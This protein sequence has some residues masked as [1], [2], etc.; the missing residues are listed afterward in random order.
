VRGVLVFF[1]LFFF[2]SLF[3]CLSVFSVSLSNG[4]SRKCS[5]ASIWC[6]WLGSAHTKDNHSRQPTFQRTEARNSNLTPANCLI[7][8][9]LGVIQPTLPHLSGVDTYHTVRSR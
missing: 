7:V 3:F 2:S 5:L 1:F 4:L 6:A 8:K 9:G